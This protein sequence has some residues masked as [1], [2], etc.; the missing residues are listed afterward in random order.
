MTILTAADLPSGGALRSTVGVVGGGAAGIVVALRLAEL[1]VDCVVCESGADDF[2]QRTQDLYAGE[3]NGYWD[4]TETRLRQF[5]GST[6][7][8]A[9]QSRPLG[10]IDLEAAAWRPG[11]AWPIEPPS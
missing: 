6:N 3:S 2:D 7:H 1:G 5:G 8:F 11:Q 10:R 4:L 9:G